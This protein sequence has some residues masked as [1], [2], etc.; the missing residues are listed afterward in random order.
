VTD[1][2][3]RQPLGMAWGPDGHLYVANQGGNEVRRYDGATGAAMGA[4]VAAG[5]GG[6]SQPSFL[7]FEPSPTLVAAVVPDPSRPTSL[8]VTGVRPGARVVLVQGAAAGTSA[9]AECPAAALAL[10]AP[11]VIAARTADESGNVVL[12]LAAF[13]G[14]T[15]LAAVDA[16]RCAATNVVPV[17]L[18]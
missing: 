11:T 8:V 4:F 13:H 6:L 9:I 1:P 2:A 18:P 17:T 5:T 7:A 16:S 14:A 12:S 10:A 3:L 15:V